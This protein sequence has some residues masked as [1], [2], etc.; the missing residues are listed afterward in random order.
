[1]DGFA[2]YWVSVVVFILALALV[3]WRDRKNVHREFILLLRKTNRGKAFLVRLGTRFPRFWKAVGT[4]G[5]VTGF[6]A[7]IWIV[8][9]FLVI[10]Y[11]NLSVAPMPSVGL[12]VP[13]PF[14]TATIGPGFYAVPFWYWIIAIGL[15]ALV[16]EGFHGIMAAME[17]VK[18]KSL[19][20]GLLVVLPLAFVEPDEKQLTKKRSWPQLRVFAAGSFANF[21]LAGVC[22]LLMSGLASAV[23]INSGV[24]FQSYP[25]T[26]IGLDKV[27]SLGGIPVSSVAELRALAGGLNE[28]GVLELVA[29]G[30]S[31]Y[32]TPHLLSTQLGTDAEIIS[33]FQD[34]PSVKGNLT[35][36]IIQ[37]DGRA[38]RDQ[39]DL[40]EVL[41]AAGPGREISITTTDGRDNKTVTLVTG[42]EPMPGFEP[43][44]NTHVIAMFEHA[45][46]GTAEFSKAMSG[47]FSAIM[48]TPPR[49]DWETIQADIMFWEYVGEHY[50][51]LKIRA[52]GKVAGLNAMAEDQFTRGGF[53]GISSVVTYV[54]VAQG[55][56]PLEEA[57][58]FI[59]GLLFWMFLINLGVGA[60]NLL[61][62]KPLDGGRMWEIL[63]KKI[64][65]KHSKNATRILSYFAL[66]LV[67]LNFFLIFK[68]F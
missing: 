11:Q 52:I 12:L 58:I 38:I 15:L 30:K 40:E 18:I 9:Q 56:E 57:F 68:A 35:G 24:A 48:G 26:G 20:W 6:V 32:I 59:Q 66:L 31:Y 53:I 7:S 51:G 62:I 60:F 16:H 61:P 27:T 5:V 17:R 65:P 29:D 39:L 42:K 44:L 19:G 8:Y 43:D 41:D 4:I 67:L 1:M 22:I 36:I 2:I 13:S 63:F 34:Y 3:M 45:V 49:T 10:T 47:T 21:I 25:A 28:T 64:I 37:I 54:K 23:F 55:L 33:V 50:P 14:P 46:P